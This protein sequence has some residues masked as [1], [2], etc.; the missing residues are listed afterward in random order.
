MYVGHRYLLPPTCRQVTFLYLLLCVQVAAAVQ[1]AGQFISYA[2][3]VRRA[4][5]QRRIGM[6]QG[7]HVS[8]RSCSMDLDE[9]WNWRYTLIFF[10]RWNPIATL[11]GRLLHPGSMLVR[12]IQIGDISK[13]ILY[14]IK[15]EFLKI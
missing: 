12:S 15:C 4:K 3:F 14:I 10:F 6:S 9:T 5:R 13:N 7:V 11:N 1:N 2:L 8:H